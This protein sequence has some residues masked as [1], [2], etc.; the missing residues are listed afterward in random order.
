MAL[1]RLNSTEYIKINLDGT[2]RI[3]K[4]IKERNQEKKGTAFELIDLKY[5]SLLEAMRK[6]KERL[7][8]D[9]GYSAMLIALETEYEKYACAH[10]QGKRVTELPLIKQYIKDVEKSLPE[11]VCEGQIGVYGDSL[12]EIYENVKRCGLFGEVEDC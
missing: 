9:P 6:D 12:A 10:R 1:K 11:L 8:Y 4:S 7:Y 5:S 2:Y 3:Y